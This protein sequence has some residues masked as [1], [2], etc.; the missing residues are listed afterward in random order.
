MILIIFPTSLLANQNILQQEAAQF[1]ETNCKET[2]TLFGK[3][4]SPVFDK[5]H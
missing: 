3:Y 5:V 4:V 2:L 1:H